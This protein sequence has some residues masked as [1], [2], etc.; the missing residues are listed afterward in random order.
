ASMQPS[1]AITDLH[2]ALS[3][4]GAERLAGAYA[5]RSLVDSGAL[6][7]GGSDAPVEKGDPM[8]ELYAASV[9]KGLDG[10]SA[11]HW[12]RE[13]ALTREEAL[14]SLTSW[15]AWATFQEDRRG[16][17]EP[18]KWADLTVLSADP[19]TVPEAEI[20][21]IQA[22]MTVVG[23]RIIFERSMTPVP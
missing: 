15:A 9:R 17:I 18:G 13:Q 1:H 16:T 2:F 4:L 19:L 14:R 7:A 20:P 12:G 3:R 10:F 11:E 8:V 22:A 23:G 5:W 21:A 6:L